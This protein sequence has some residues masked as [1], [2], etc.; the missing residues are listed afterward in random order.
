MKKTIIPIIFITLVCPS[1]LFG[2]IDHQWSVRTGGNFSNRTRQV[3]TDTEDNIILTGEISFNT[4]IYS[5]IIL[6][7]YSPEG[8]SLWCYY[9]GKSGQTELVNGLC[10][11]DSNNIY[12]TGAYK[13]I[14][15]FGSYNGSTHTVSSK[16]DWDMYIARFSPKG[17]IEWIT[18]YGSTIQEFG[19]D[20]I[21]NSSDNLLM[22][23][24]YNNE[25]ATSK[26]KGIVL[27]VNPQTGSIENS[28]TLSSTDNLQLNE[29]ELFQT[30]YQIAGSFSGTFA[31]NKSAGAND[32][33]IGYIEPENLQFS[34]EVINGNYS[35]NLI[36]DLANINDEFNVVGYEYEGSNSFSFTKIIGFINRNGYISDMGI[37]AKL[38]AVTGGNKYSYF[39]G[40]FTDNM[41]VGLDVYVSNGFNIFIGKNSNN[42]FLYL[43]SFKVV[44]GLLSENY[45]RLTT[46][47]KGKLIMAGVF[48]GTLKFGNSPDS[49]VSKSLGDIFIAQFDVQSSNA[50]IEDIRVKDISTYTYEKINSTYEVHVPI[51]T[52]LS[53]IYLE[54][55]ISE[56]AS[57]SPNPATVSNYISQVNFTVKSEDGAVNW[58]Y[59]IEIKADLEEQTDLD[60]TEFHDFSVYPN[61]A[62]QTIQLKI[63]GFIGNRL[64]CLVRSTDGRLVRSLNIDNKQI[65][66]NINDFE[67]GVYFITI[68]G[69][70]NQLCK[71]FIKL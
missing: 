22:A 42:K 28:T 34:L 45:I 71:K 24:G 26:T 4:D 54:F 44:Q 32:A 46:N 38:E 23:V 56:N 61:P 15:N 18:S 33:F 7:K 1:V 5:D 64:N 58:V 41:N 40:N 12:I 43:K 6:T 13:G 27:T 69:D 37:S 19:Q 16:G 31:S 9:I 66:L 65:T 10:L 59:Y 70:N 29:I 60:N 35:D 67:Q 14:V 17:Q 48:A 62:T 55:D 2:Q 53:D 25:T 36:I 52:N 30:K 49:V 20:L 11:D 63:P 51:G 50:E 8:D 47:S 39:A 21:Y 3:I 57:I 68:S